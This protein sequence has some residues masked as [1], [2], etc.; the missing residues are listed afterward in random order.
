[1]P[2][3]PVHRRTLLQKSFCGGGLKFSEPQ[4]RRLKN[5]VIKP[6]CAKLTGDSGSG[7]E[8][9]LIGDYRLFR[10]LAEN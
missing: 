3:Y 1:M 7:F 6:P 4:A 8:A 2:A 9:A 10:A 5:D